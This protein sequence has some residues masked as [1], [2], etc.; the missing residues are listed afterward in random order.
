MLTANAIDALA[1]SDQ[2][3]F[4][5]VVPELGAEVPSNADAAFMAALAS[6]EH[7]DLSVLPLSI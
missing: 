5:P 1:I 6:G 2:H 4:T 7:L 3:P